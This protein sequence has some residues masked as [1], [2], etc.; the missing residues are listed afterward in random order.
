VTQKPRDLRE[1]LQ[2]EVERLFHDLVYHR[3]PSSHFTEPR[4]SPLADLVVSEHAARVLV[5]LAGV[6]RES[7]HVR[8]RGNLL[9]LTGRRNPRQEPGGAHYHLAEIYFGEFRRV[10]QL[11]WEADEERVEAYFKDGMLEIHLRRLV[12]RRVQVPVDGGRP[13]RAAV[14]E[15]ER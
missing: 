7:V 12:P 4:W 6:P 9:E 11:P 8:L 1:N 2:R 13:G 14:S 10:V 15:G 3:H 5:E